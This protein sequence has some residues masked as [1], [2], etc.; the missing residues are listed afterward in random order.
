MS[1]A[2]AAAVPTA[3]LNEKIR[4]SLLRLGAVNGGL[5][6]LA[7]KARVPYSTL[8]NQINRQH[9]ILAAVIPPIV[10][11]TGDQTLLSML[12]DACGF[13]VAPKPRF[14]RTR[15][16][17]RRQET[18]LS[19]AVGQALEVIEQ[20]LSDGLINSLEREQIQRALNRVCAHSVEIG[21]TIEKGRFLRKRGQ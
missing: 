6:D 5:R 1:V 10:S 19:I 12:A 9:G 21:E 20:A 16:E 3:N 8:W 11:A 17:I 13:I 15:R 4:V 14:L 18:G 7:E 2:H